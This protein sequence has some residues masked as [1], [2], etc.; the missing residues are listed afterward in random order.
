MKAY[1]FAPSHRSGVD[2]DRM[3]DALRR[4]DRVEDP[5]YHPPYDIIRI[6]DNSFRIT[7]LVPGISVDELS[8][9]TRENVLSV[10]ATP[11]SDES[12]HTYLHRG[13]GLRG[14]TRT[15]QLAD[16]VKVS[17]ASLRDGLLIIDLNR[18]VPEA[19]KPRK[20]EIKT[21]RA[22]GVGSIGQQDAA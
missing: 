21:A 6:D 4:A 19:L 20:I 22:D 1:S 17:Q 3:M 12:E 16:H 18:Q 15:F 7:F 11:N 13:I 9:E 14:F 10:T 5:G 8:L 2:F